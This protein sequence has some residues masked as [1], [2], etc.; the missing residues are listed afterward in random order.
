MTEPTTFDFEDGRGP[1]P[2]HRHRNPDGSVGG[3]VSDE[4]SGQ[5]VGCVLELS[6]A[7][8]AYGADSG[9]FLTLSQAKAFVERNPRSVHA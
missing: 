7:W 4:A 1:V 3:W 2:A 9:T 6:G 5:E 8:N